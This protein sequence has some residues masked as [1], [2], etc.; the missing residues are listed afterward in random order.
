M[1]SDSLAHCVSSAINSGPVR[2]KQTLRHLRCRPLLACFVRVSCLKLLRSL[3]F[4]EICGFSTH[5]KCASSA[6]SCYHIS[7]SQSRVTSLPQKVLTLTADVAAAE[8]LDFGAEASLTSS[9]FCFNGALSGS[10]DCR[11]HLLDVRSK[12]KYIHF[13]QQ[14]IR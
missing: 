1:H 8:V 2:S 12:T 4:P 10:N 11:F 3:F 5:K 14:A 7:T 6:S 13:T 9:S